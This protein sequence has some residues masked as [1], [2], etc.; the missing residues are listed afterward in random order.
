MTAHKARVAQEMYRSGQYTVSAIAQTLGISRASLYRH[1]DT[2]GYLWG[3]CVRGGSPFGN[4]LL[5]LRIHQRT[6]Q[7]GRGPVHGAD[8]CRLPGRPRPR[9]RPSSGDDPRGDARRLGPA[10]HLGAGA[11]GGRLI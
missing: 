7:R 9:Q 3:T 5:V 8:V 2:T 4:S 11:E 6:L 10:S 1:L